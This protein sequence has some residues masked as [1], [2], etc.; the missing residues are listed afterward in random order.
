MP[1]RDV[2]NVPPVIGDKAQ[3]RMA[4]EV[5]PLRLQ[6]TL[7]AKEWK[8]VTELVS[9]DGRVHFYGKVWLWPWMHCEKT[10]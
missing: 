4:T 5:A 8:F 1:K 7:K 3:K 10:S 2:Y 6:K 9:G